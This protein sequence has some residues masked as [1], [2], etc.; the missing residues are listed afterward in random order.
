[1]HDILSGLHIR[2]NASDILEAV[3]NVVSY[4]TD[5]FKIFQFK[6][7]AAYQKKNDTFV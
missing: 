1:M 4:M 2:L 7:F 5:H 6:Y 3:L